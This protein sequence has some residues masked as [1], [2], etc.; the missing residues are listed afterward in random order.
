MHDIQIGD[1]VE[2]TDTI[3]YYGIVT[4]RMEHEDWFH[5]QNIVKG[6][7]RMTNRYKINPIRITDNFLKFFFRSRS[8]NTYYYNEDCVFAEVK[9]KSFEYGLRKVQYTEDVFDIK[10]YLINGEVD[11][12]KLDLECPRVR[13]MGELNTILSKY[14]ITPEDIVKTLETMKKWTKV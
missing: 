3:K 12:E 14:G 8:N 5:V 4:D 1:I 10:P 2:C 11:Y 7:S 13:T 9:H 6:N